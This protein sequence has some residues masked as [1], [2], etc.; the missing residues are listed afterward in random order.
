MFDDY[1]PNDQKY[2]EPE[3]LA[4]VATHGLGALLALAGLVALLGEA[5]P[6]R[7]SM[8]TVA[9]AVYGATLV[10]AYLSSTLYH[11]ARCRR[12][13]RLFKVCDHA[14][15]FL[16]IGG[17]YTP[18][19]GLVLGDAGGRDLLAVVWGLALTG[20]AAKVYTVHRFEYLFVAFY[21]GL[22]W[23]GVTM[24]GP[25]TERL[26]PEGVAWLVGGGL[27]YTA[28]VI[29]YLWERLPFNHAVWH[30][31]ALAG[32]ACHFVAIFRYV[33]PPIA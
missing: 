22:G 26:P 25:M 28:G 8:L 21:L 24:A 23:L 5:A 19:A 16:L 27:A 13:K 10:L 31:F 29:F 30:L 7:D 4:N 17:T 2:T 11:S 1:P 18:F 12:K 33:V 14:A 15:I 20:V 9:L 6:R 3:E 32:S